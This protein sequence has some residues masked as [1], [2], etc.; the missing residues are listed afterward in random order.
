MPAA[1]A[2]SLSAMVDSVYATFGVGATY[3]DRDGA[4]VDLT[5][6]VDR[7]LG[8][9]GE[10]AQVSTRQA[11]LCVRTSELSGGPRRGESFTTVDGD[12]FVVDSLVQA[13]ELEHRVLVAS[14]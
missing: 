12:V 1:A 2:A 9:Y 13:D 7:N 14:S 5:V 4:S 3:L 11:V 8:N 10:V 6:V